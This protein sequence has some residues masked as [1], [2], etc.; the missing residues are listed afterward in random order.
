MKYL[1][2]AG[3]LLSKRATGAA[4]INKFYGYSGPNFMLDG[5]VDSPLAGDRTGEAA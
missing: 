3:S 2:S 5:R 4:D 1:L